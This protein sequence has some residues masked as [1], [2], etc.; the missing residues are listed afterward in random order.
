MIRPL[1]ELLAGIPSVIYG[2]GNFLP[3]GPFLGSEVYPTISKWFGGSI[4][5]LSSTNAY[6]SSAVITASI[7]LAIMILPIIVTLSEDAICSVSTEMK[8]PRLVQERPTGRL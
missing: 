1:T 2:Y 8:Q 6:Y 3:F 4:W 7:V 5:F